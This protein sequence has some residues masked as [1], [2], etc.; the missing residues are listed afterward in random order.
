MGRRSLCGIRPGGIA[1]VAIAA[2]LWVRGPA[3]ADQ[4]PRLDVAFLV[5]ATGSM[6]DEIDAVKARIRE[7]VAQIAGGSPTPDVRFGIVAYRDRG[8]EYVTR[9]HDLTA[10]IDAVFGH[11]Q[12][13]RADGGGDDEESVNQA[14][15]EAVHRVRWTPD[16]D[17]LK[18]VF[19]VGD[20]PPHMIFLQSETSDP[21]LDT[22]LGHAYAI[23]SGDAE[24][25]ADVD[26]PYAALSRS[27]S[28]TLEHYRLLRFFVRRHIQIHSSGY[29]QIETVLVNSVRLLGQLDSIRK[30]HENA[31]KGRVGAFTEPLVRLQCKKATHGKTTET[32]RLPGPCAGW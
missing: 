20:Y 27:D 1:V 9:F 10:D 19:L 25:P 32:S 13:F 17:V 14:L 31:A 22:P 30:Q 28:A 21:V 15:H 12:S 29:L 7:M 8:D 3:L 4:G 6:A 26:F 24:V 5:D 16:G 18:V 11:L 2:A 23:P